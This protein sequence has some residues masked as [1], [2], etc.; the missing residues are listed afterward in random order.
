[1]ALSVAALPV[2][3]LPA[4]AGAVAASPA[5][6]AT[7]TL[8][9]FVADGAVA[10]VRGVVAAGGLTVT[11]V[12]EVVL[13]GGAGAGADAGGFTTVVLPGAGTTSVV[14]FSTTVGGA[15]LVT[16]VV[17]AT[18][19]RV[20]HQASAPNTTMTRATMPITIAVLLF[21]LASG[22]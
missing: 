18:G 19:G 1:V 9:L 16:T 6:G 14:W 4:G 10:G 20:A 2:A 21:C 3:V 13:V 17:V 5:G 7:L 11:V 22:S 15:G 12:F 8:V